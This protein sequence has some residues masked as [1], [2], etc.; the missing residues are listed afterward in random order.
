MAK[1]QGVT[2][3]QM[4]RQM[5]EAD[6]DTGMKEVIGTLAGK[7]VKVQPSL[8]Y[9]I[10]SQMKVKKRRAARQKV[11]TTATVNGQDPL[12]IIRQV[13]GLAEQVGGIARLKEIV[14]AMA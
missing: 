5:L 8:V 7:G 11:A 1:Q 6:P 10:K 2:K 9:A 12:V 14:E 13:K 4:I 3:S